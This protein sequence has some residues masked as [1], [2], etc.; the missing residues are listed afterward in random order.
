MIEGDID[1]VPRL[2]VGKSKM[3]EDAR[4]RGWVPEIA[5]RG[6]IDSLRMVCCMMLQQSL[7]RAD[8]RQLLAILAYLRGSTP[9]WIGKL[10]ESVTAKRV[11]RQV[12]EN[13]HLVKW[14]KSDNFYKAPRYWPDQVVGAFRWRLIPS[15][16]EVGA[17][18]MHKHP[19][20]THSAVV[21]HVVMLA[22]CYGIPVA[23]IA[24]ALDLSEEMI[25]DYIYK[26]ISKLYDLPSFVVWA[27]AT[28]FRKAPLPPQMLELLGED[29]MRRKRLTRL[30]Q[31]PFSFERRF[32]TPWVQSP[33]IRAYLIYGTPKKP[34]LSGKH[35]DK[36]LA[37]ARS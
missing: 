11:L 2:N 24:E 37:E 33:G 31:S 10:K 20:T 27:T 26:A 9:I 36:N 8:K 28:N 32:F 18:V 21:P 1:E 17:I 7:Q 14:A 35:Y 12:G 34:R 13:P 15:P 3:R 29:K 5:G 16:R 25:Y 19:Y 23:S 30:I 22:Y 6:S 4:V